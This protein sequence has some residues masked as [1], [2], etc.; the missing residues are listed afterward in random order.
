M[1][2]WAIQMSSDE[3][4]QNEVEVVAEAILCLCGCCGASL[5]EEPRRHDSKAGPQDVFVELEA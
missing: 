2:D 5:R 3:S 1:S 4:A